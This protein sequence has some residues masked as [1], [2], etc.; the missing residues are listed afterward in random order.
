[1]DIIVPPLSQTSD[2]LILTAWLKKVG[3]RVTKGEAL[4]EVETDKA[5]L[6]VESPGTGT[7]TALLAEPGTEVSVRSVIGTIAA[8]EPA[9]VAE[10]PKPANGHPAPHVP[11]RTRAHGSASATPRPDRLFASPRARS[12]ADREGIVLNGIAATG[13]RGMIVERDVKAYLAQRAEGPA[14]IPRPLPPSKSTT[15]E[16]AS[17]SVPTVEAVA[18]SALAEPRGASRRVPLSPTRRTI[19]R[20]LQASAQASVP[21]TLTRD[22]DA[23]EVV[24]LRQRLLADLGGQGARPTYTDF[25]VSIVARVLPQH[26]QFNATFDGEALEVFEPI[27][28]G[29]AVDTER[30]LLVPVL[31]NV[32]H[33]GLVA[34]A[35]ERQQMVQR[36]LDGKSTPDEFS[37]GTFTLSNLG[38]LG[39]DAFTPIL[40]PPQVA[41]L[42]LGRLRPVALPI[43]GVVVPRQAMFLSLTFDHRAV[44][45]A[46]A[47]R[48]LGDIAALIEHP[49][50]IWL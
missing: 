12:L 43:A 25:L 3:D 13:P 34:L 18:A 11:A 16:G 1:M 26:P 47:A 29:L 7:L 4:F 14:P 40:N 31:R 37:G 28:M 33:K 8:T 49:D 45:G 30:G 32:E 10:S 20:R 24:A 5:T 6:E 46:P 19:A 15:G 27:H 38:G 2:T 36:A 50:R 48:F 22:T 21:V 23:T 35:T 9:A 42:G 41:I 17:E 39:I 44:D